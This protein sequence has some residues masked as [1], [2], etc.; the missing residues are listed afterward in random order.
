MLT[1]YCLSAAGGHTRSHPMRRW[2]RLR[3]PHPPTGLA[4]FL[5]FRSFHHRWRSSATDNI[6]EK[7]TILWILM[8]KRPKLLP[9]PPG[10][11]RKA[12][13]DLGPW[14]QRPGPLSEP[15]AS[16]CNFSCRLIRL[17]IH[18]AD[19]HDKLKQ[20]HGMLGIITERFDEM[21][22]SFQA[23]SRVKMKRDAA[24]IT[25]KAKCPFVPD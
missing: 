23:M 20:A 18:H 2:N 3:Q 22:Q 21:E 7:R 9:R 6:L 11:W 8:N 4:R 19:I 13:V 5:G 15:A 25:P 14:L 1:D 17:Q 24:H 10:L 16:P 12:L